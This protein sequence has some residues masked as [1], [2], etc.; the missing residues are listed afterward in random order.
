MAD[1][2]FTYDAGGVTL[3]YSPVMN[4]IFYNTSGLYSSAGSI[5]KQNFLQ[6][7]A[8]A[9]PTSSPS[10]VWTGD[11]ANF[12]FYVTASG[13]VNSTGT[14]YLTPSPVQSGSNCYNYPPTMSN[15][16]SQVYSFGVPDNSTPNNYGINVPGVTNPSVPG[17][18]I[19]RTRKSYYLQPGSDGQPL[20]SGVCYSVPSSYN[21][22]IASYQVP[23]TLPGQV[24]YFEKAFVNPPLVFITNSSGPISL[25]YMNRNAQGLY[26]GMVIVAASSPSTQGL[27]GTS[28]YTANSYTFSY[29]LLSDEKPLYKASSD[30]GVKVFN[31]SGTEVF[32]SS[33]FCSTI[34]YTTTLRPWFFINGYYRPPG[35]SYTGSIQ[36]GQ[37]STQTFTKTASQGFCINNVNS[38]I[39]H[40]MYTSLVFEPGSGSLGDGPTTFYGHYVTVTDTQTTLQA[41][42]TNGV[43][44]NPLP[45]ILGWANSWEYFDH[46]YNPTTWIWANYAY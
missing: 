33:Y 7:F 34:G 24:I 13:I 16:T 5:P 18:A 42:G 12:T 29:F 36:Y 28:W 41:Y 14:Q 45:N 4:A 25:H 11:P 35:C 22:A 26:D 2:L 31:D 27:A 1:G 8:M 3:M 37:G 43:F 30:Y 38:I 40:T 17:L 21:S 15:V 46:Y 32:D 10:Y 23:G 6:L 39:G 19:D 20:R 9:T 44:M